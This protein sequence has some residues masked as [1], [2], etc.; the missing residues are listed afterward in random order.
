MEYSNRISNLGNGLK[1]AGYTVF[2]LEK[3]RM[4][5]RGLYNSFH[6]ISQV[7]R[8]TGLPDETAISQLVIYESSFKDS[9]EIKEKDC[10]TKSSRAEFMENW[11]NFLDFSENNGKFQVAKKDTIRS[12]VYGTIH[13]MTLLD[14]REKLITIQNVMYA[15]DILF[16]LISTSQAVHHGFRTEIYECEY[17]P[18][19][20]CCG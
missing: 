14:R 7:I 19:H 5:L 3:K 4:L 11:D 6:V 1:A 8:S 12:E 16:N 15:P 2:E 10:Y 17:E 9:N 18:S 13:I 20:E